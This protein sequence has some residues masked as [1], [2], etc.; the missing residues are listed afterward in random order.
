MEQM[1]LAYEKRRN[2]LY[3]GI[4]KI[5]SLHMLRP[6]GAFYAWIRFDTSMDS[7]TLCNYLLD[8]AKIAGVPGS[9]YGEES[10]TC[11]RFSFAASEDLLRQ[12]LKRLEA[13]CPLP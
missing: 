12:M 6:Q 8:H 2:L 13:L 3:E 11:V 7:E 4:R 10:C 9:A 5:P 1:R